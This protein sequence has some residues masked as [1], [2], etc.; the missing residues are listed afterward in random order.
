VEEYRKN[1]QENPA[2]AG[3]PKPWAASPKHCLTDSSRELDK[4][5]PD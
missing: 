1:V 2:P 4:W 3:E 5:H